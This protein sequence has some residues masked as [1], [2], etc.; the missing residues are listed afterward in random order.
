[1]FVIMAVATDAGLLDSWPVLP[2]VVRSPVLPYWRSHDGGLNEPG[3]KFGPAIASGLLQKHRDLSGGP[4]AEPSSV[5][6]PIPSFGVSQTRHPEPT[7]AAECVRHP[8]W[9]L[10]RLIE[11]RIHTDNTLEALMNRPLCSLLLCALL[12]GCESTSRSSPMSGGNSTSSMGGISAVNTPVAG[13]SISPGG[14]AMMPS[15][16][17]AMGG[18]RPSP[19]PEA[20]GSSMTTAGAPS[21]PTG[22]GMPVEAAGG[23]NPPVD[24]LA[25]LFAEPSPEE[26]RQ[27]RWISPSG[28]IRSGWNLAARQNSEALISTSSPT[29]LP[30]NEHYGA[31]RFPANYDATEIP[32]PYR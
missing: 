12:F 8:V 2:L 29:G 27:F 1:M 20:A 5:P 4:L 25:A 23:E 26:L 13:D 7:D 30:G 31:I 15:M 11:Y 24:E 22:G 14:M 9:S 10:N 16:P 21:Q 3:E 17:A 19:Q 32:N 18:N 6:L 28:Y